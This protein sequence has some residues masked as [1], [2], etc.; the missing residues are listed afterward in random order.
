[1]RSLLAI[2]LMSG[3][4][5]D[6]VDATLLRTDGERIDDVGPGITRPYDDRERDILRAALTA[7]VGLNDR[8]VRPP[9]LAEA[10]R[11]VTEAHIEAVGDLLR[12][13]ALRGGDVDIV[14]FHGQT[15][16]HAPER[17]LTIQIGDA[18]ALAEAIG[19]PVV[20]D[21]R[22]ADVAAG[23]EGA[24]FVPVY[25]RALAERDGLP[26]PLAVVNL[27]GVANIT[28]IGEDGRMIACDTGPASAMIDDWVR[29]HAG[30]GFDDGGRIAASGTVDGAALAALLDNPY[31][32]REAPKSLDRDAFSSAPVAALTLED[33]AATLTA[34]SAVALARGLDLMPEKP[35][36]L[37]LCGGGRHN[38]TLVAEIGRATG[39]AEIKTADELGWSG[40]FI[41]AEAFGFMAVRRM[42]FLPLSFPMTTGVAAPTLGGQLARP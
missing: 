29:L 10:E 13:A 9:A 37:V 26:R 14:G 15:V 30:K 24:P 27:G 25:H 35:V 19:I 39:V 17:R 38:R 34:F 41:E 6:G 21:F 28:W 2:G 22:G 20:Y 7:A 8:Y 31:F 18:T 4:S 12:L 40:D 36:L 5:M 32:D 23:G 1:M 42:R 11:I 16:L 3:T 33:G